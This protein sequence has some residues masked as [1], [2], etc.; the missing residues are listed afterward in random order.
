MKTPEFPQFIRN[1]P[2]ADLPVEDL[3]G[4]IL[5]G[6]RGQVLL[7]RVDE[8]KNFPEHEHGDQWGIV[9]DGEME[10]TVAGKTET[11]RRGDSYFIPSGTPHKA[12]IRR[13]FRALDIFADRDRYRVEGDT[14]G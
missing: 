14:S 13:G 11:Y 4:W 9:I 7:L 5:Q 1:L 3:T 2:Q 6:E 10:L 12:I 8:E